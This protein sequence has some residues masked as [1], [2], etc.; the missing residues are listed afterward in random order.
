MALPLCEARSAHVPPLINV[1]RLPATAHTLLVCDVKVTLKPDE[2]VALIANGASPMTFVGS[3]SKVMVCVKRL[4]LKLRITSGAGAKFGSPFC[5]AVMVQLPAMPLNVTKVP[6]TAHTPLE[7][8]DTSKPDDAVA[9][10]AN[11]GSVTK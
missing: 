6:S 1:T 10:M 7:L 2:A 11:A 5:V 9:V 3:V 4:T 8:N